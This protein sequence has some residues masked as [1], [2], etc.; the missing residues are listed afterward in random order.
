[1]LFNFCYGPRDVEWLHSEVYS[2]GIFISAAF[3][4]CVILPQSPLHSTGVVRGLINS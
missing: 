4:S 3:H 1:M 2:G